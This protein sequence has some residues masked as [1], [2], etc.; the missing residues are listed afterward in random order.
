MNDE[1]LFLTDR[2]LGVLT[3]YLRFMG[4]DTKSA[5]SLT[6]GDSR[7]DT[8]LLD[9]AKEEGRYLLTRDR[10]LAERGKNYSAVLLKSDDVLCQVKQLF[11]AGLIDGSHS[12]GMQR[13]VVCNTSLRPASSDDINNTPYAPSEKKELKFMWCPLCRKLYWTGTHSLNLEKRL[14][15]I[16][17]R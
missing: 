13:C 1:N 7:E 5:V 6:A 11:L 4:Y 8:V 3:R 17:D 14:K 16:F 15:K 2:M 12:L 10:E 9:I